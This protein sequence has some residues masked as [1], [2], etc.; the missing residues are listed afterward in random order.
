M[1][2]AVGGKSPVMALNSVGLAGAVG[3]ED[4]APFAGRDPHVDVGKRHQR[5]ELAATPSAPAHAR[6]RSSRRAAD[7][8]RS[9]TWLASSPCHLPQG[10]LSRPTGPMRDE[11]GLAECRASG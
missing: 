1:R 6:R 3:A 7:V 2:P 9:A 8:T 4:R 10:G 5:A 11:F